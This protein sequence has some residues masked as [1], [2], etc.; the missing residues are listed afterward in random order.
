[1]F[2]FSGICLLIQ[3]QELGPIEAHPFGAPFQAMF[4]FFREFDIAEQRNLNSVAGDTGKIPQFAQLGFKFAEC[5][6]GGFVKLECLLVRI[7][8]NDTLVAID[9]E[10]VAARDIREE[11]ADTDNSRYFERAR[12]DG[13]VA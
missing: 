12:H 3:V 2:L 11:S 8:D 6:L 9:D 7:E 10:E 4:S 5:T 13:R 1:M